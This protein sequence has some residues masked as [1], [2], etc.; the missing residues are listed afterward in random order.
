VM[1]INIFTDN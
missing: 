1:F